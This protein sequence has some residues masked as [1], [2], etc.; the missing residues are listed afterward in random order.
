MSS[1]KRQTNSEYPLLKPNSAS[2]KRNRRFVYT[3]GSVCFKQTEGFITTNRRFSDA[4]Y[5]IFQGN[6]YNLKRESA[7]SCN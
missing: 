3:K 5:C 6:K 4:I 1:I 2:F 7:Y